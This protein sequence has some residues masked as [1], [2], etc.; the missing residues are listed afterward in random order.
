[1]SQRGRPLKGKES[2]D[3]KI[4]I[5]I[6]DVLK[7]GLGDLALESRRSLSDYCHYVLEQHL[8]A[9]QQETS[10]PGITSN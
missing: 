8:W 10:Q 9:V 2:R 7:K 5:C 6:E 3:A 4:V 1:M